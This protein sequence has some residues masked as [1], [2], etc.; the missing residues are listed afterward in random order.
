MNSNLEDKYNER[1]GLYVLT[2]NAKKPY[3]IGMT[4]RPIWKRINSYVNC[5]SAVDGHWIHLLLTW[6]IDAPPDAQVVE[7]FVFKRLEKYRMNSTQRSNANK[8]EHFNCSLKIIKAAFEEAK[9][10]YKSS[11]HFNYIEME[12]KT[13]DNKTVK[14]SK[15]VGKKNQS[16]TVE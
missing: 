13:M 10:H 12:N 9:Q 16:V 3:R 6:D 15:I 1:K 5:P 8:T 2:T 14:V 7:S 11:K 4:N